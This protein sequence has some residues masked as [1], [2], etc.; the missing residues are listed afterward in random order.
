ME[1]GRQFVYS[2]QGVQ[3]NWNICLMVKPIAIKWHDGFDERGM[4]D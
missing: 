1:V 3:Q 2:Q 4:R